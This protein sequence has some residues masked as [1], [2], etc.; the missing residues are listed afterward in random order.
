MK[1]LI[2]YDIVC[3][4]CGFASQHTYYSITDKMFDSKSEAEAYQTQ[5][6]LFD[7]EI[8][9]KVIAEPVEH[10]LYTAKQLINRIVVATKATSYEGY[11][12]GEGNYRENIAT[13]QPYKGNR[14]SS[15]PVHYAAIKEYLIKHHKAQVVEGQEADDMLGINQGTDTCIA[16]I[17]K[18]LNMISGLHYNWQKDE[19]YAVDQQ[20]ADKWFFTQL[21]MGDPTDNIRGIHRMGLKKAEKVL[22]DL[23]NWDEMELAVAMAYA[24][25]DYEDPEAA[26]IENGQLLWIR[27]QEGE[28]WLP[29]FLGGCVYEG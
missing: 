27:R 13:I 10:A 8:T 6:E 16:T 19:L 9:P 11:L 4:S 28:M 21:L 7:E 2:D 26:M 24:C 18:D 14:T 12:T 29:E 15:K 17:D 1:T 23:T 5:F 25:S 3:Y 22:Q 20:T